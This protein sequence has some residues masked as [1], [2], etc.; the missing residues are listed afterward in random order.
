M[1][2]EFKF[3]AWDEDRKQYAQVLG[4][5]FNENSG[6][7]EIVKAKIDGET[8][9]G[10]RKRFVLEQYTGLKDKNG[11][12]IYEGDIINLPL[13]FGIREFGFVAF[14]N[15]RF[16]IQDYEWEDGSCH[17]VDFYDYNVPNQDFEIIGNIHENS[18]LL[19]PTL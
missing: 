2:R 19:A 3:R 12:E 7:I 16:L 1:T 15:G 5:E 4:L 11:K 8:Y 10:A 17:I 9:F 14:T 13:D 6:E 18:E